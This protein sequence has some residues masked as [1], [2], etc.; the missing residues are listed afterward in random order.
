MMR[1]AVSML[2]VALAFVSCNQSDTKTADATPDIFEVEFETT[3][4]NFTVKAIR[5]W[6]PLGADRFY[7]LVS[8]GFYED[9]AL[10]RVVDNFVAQFGLHG[11]PAVTAKWKDAVIKDDPVSTGN[12]R[13]TISFASR[14]PNTRTT[15]LFIN[16]KNNKPLDAMGFSPFAEVTKGMDVVDSFYQAKPVPDQEKMTAQGNAYLRKNFPQLDYI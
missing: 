12:K 16:F 6:A 2:L 7:D 15:Q 10:F 8:Q 5:A 9:I 11:D 1:I 3:K 4:G 13:G 14:G